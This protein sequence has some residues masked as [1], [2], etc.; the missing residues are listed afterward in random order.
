M[1]SECL[2]QIYNVDMN[3]CFRLII[4]SKWE[5]CST[6]AVRCLAQAVQIYIYNTVH[7]MS[8]SK[9]IYSFDDGQ[10]EWL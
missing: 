2:E 10:H 1:Q 8:K 9:L 7:F 5:L 6:S 3:D 4:L